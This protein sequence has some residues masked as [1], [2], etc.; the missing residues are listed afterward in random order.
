MEGNDYYEILGVPKNASEAEIKTAYR[1]KAL[2]CH[3][4]RNKD[5]SA[6]QQFQQ[7]GE[8][9][10][11]LGD[12][13]KRR[14]YDRETAGGKRSFGTSVNAEDTFAHFFSGSGSTAYFSTNG[15]SGNPED[16]FSHFFSSSSA[17][18][19]SSSED[20]DFT[21][22]FRS[23]MP[24]PA[25]PPYSTSSRKKFK[26]ARRQPSTYYPPPSSFGF[27]EFSRNHQFQEKPRFV[28]R[29]LPVSLEDLYTGTTKKLKVTRSLSNETTDKILTVNV[30][31]GMKTGSKISFPSEGDA[32]PSGKMQDLVF[33]IEEKPHASFIRHGDNL[34]TTV[35]LTLKEALTGFK[36]SIPR[37]DGQ[38]VTTVE[39]Q[40][41]IIQNGQ[42]EILIG[43][44]MPNEE[45]G[46][47]GD[48]IV[49]FQVEFPE[50]LTPEQTEGLKN[51]L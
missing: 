49:R 35:K 33:E 11:V 19:Q 42:E 18:S 39:T 5:K 43:E 51:I 23:Y 3:P 40:N 1:K 44:G 31:P 13:N 28:K 27:D 12:K 41:R 17:M 50:S 6:K 32:L 38:T 36:K 29:S 48:L 47:K 26:S 9:F 14:Q 25:S 2:K 16:L 15:T 21:D 4:D 45:T 30:K 24:K 20:E 10:E 34:Q 46:E 8:A 22:L 37:L 7:I